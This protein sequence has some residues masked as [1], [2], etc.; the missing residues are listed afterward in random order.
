MPT[1]ILPLF[2]DWKPKISKETFALDCQFALISWQI[3]GCLGADSRG[4]PFDWQ[5]V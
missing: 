4:I 3:G 1:Q 2:F 5:V